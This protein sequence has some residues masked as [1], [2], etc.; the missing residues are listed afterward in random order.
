MELSEATKEDI[1]LRN[2]L[3]KLGFQEL[4]DIAVFV[5]IGALK[6]AENPV[7]HA[8]SKHID[9]RPFHSRSIER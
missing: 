4:A 2:V 6:L 3:I 9:D 1:Y 8:R 5:D 7:F